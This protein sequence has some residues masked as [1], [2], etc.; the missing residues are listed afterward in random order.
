[1]IFDFGRK[2]VIT[3]DRVVR[4]SVLT[5]PT[6]PESRPARL[7]H[8]EEPTFDAP[9]LA[10][11]LQSID[12]AGLDRLGYGALGFDAE[13]ILHQY[14]RVMSAGTGIA[15]ARLLGQNVFVTVSPCM[16]NS[17]VMQRF[18]DTMNNGQALDEIVDFVLTW[19][20]RP[21]YVRLRLVASP[22]Q[23]LRYVLVERR[24]PSV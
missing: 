4:L 2:G 8:E 12:A 16:N 18:E 19:R 13:G 7:V 17:M 21:T 1:M 22:G 24:V 20:M 6:A 14:N 23:P 5:T 9:G 11:W 3:F 15:A 10:G